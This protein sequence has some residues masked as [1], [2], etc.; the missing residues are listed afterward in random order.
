MLELLVE[1][2]HVV[3]VEGDELAVDLDAGEPALAQLAQELAEL[4]LAMI[5][6][7]REEE[8]LGAFGQRQDLADDLVGALRG[9]ELAAEVAELLADAGV[10]HAEVV[11][12]LGD[13][14]DG[15]AGL[16]EA[17]FCSMA[18]VGERPRRCSTCGRSSCPRNWRA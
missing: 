2:G 17:L 13:G 8:Q 7:G 6:E 9:D 12:D 1:L 3:G 11:V 5:D 15:G 14:P 16:P 10:E 18:I 4:A